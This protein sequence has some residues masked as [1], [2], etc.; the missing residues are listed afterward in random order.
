VKTDAAHIR[1]KCASGWG[2]GRDLLVVEDEE[3]GREMLFEPRD[4]GSVD[5]TPADLRLLSLWKE[6][7][8]DA[9]GAAA[10]VEDSLAL[11]RPVARQ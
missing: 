9:T 2:S 1:S 7:T 10:E 5:V 4:A 11:E 8:K 6:V 3:R